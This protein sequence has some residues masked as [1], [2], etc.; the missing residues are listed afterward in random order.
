M[1]A[2]G[3]TIYCIGDSADIAIA[4]LNELYIWCLNNR[5]TPHPRKSEVMVLSR[6]MMMSPVAPGYIG[7]SILKL[8][9]Q[10]RLLG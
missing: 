3:T 4:Q 7:E 5:L 10:T 2:D 1:Y 8:V 6:G 9:T